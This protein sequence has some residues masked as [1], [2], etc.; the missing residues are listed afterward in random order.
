MELARSLTTGAAARVV[1]LAARLHGEA[2]LFGLRSPVDPLDRIPFPLR[3]FLEADETV[4]VLAS[5]G[6][7][8]GCSF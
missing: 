1:G 5:R 8:N 3:T 7:Y 4:S 2:T 6:C